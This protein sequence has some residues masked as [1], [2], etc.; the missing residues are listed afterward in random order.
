MKGTELN[1]SKKS[2]TY[3]IINEFLQ[4]SG[5]RHISIRVSLGQTHSLHLLALFSLALHSWWQDGCQWLLL[6]SQ[7][8]QWSIWTSLF[9]Y[10]G[11][12]SRHFSLASWEHMFWCSDWPDPVHMLIPDLGVNPAPLKMLWLRVGRAGSPKGTELG[13]SN[14]CLQLL[15]DSE[16]LTNLPTLGPG[17]SPE[18]WEGWS[19]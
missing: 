7:Q 12:K 11:I 5:I 13:R 19:L 15:I 2:H 1:L 8:P 6:S 3:T 18:K 10:S 16:I 17:F 14:R 4:E 9:Q